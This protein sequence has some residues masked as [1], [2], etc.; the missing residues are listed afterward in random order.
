MRGAGRAASW[1]AP[2]FSRST[3]PGCLFRPQGGSE[4]KPLSEFR[5]RWVGAGK[6]VKYSRLAL[7]EPRLR[8][9]QGRNARLGD[10]GV[11]TA[12]D[13]ADP[14]RADAL[15]ANHDGHATFQHALD[16]GSTEE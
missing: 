8:L 4:G 6:P 5:E 2:G 11:F 7:P 15:A 12:L 14:D 1:K 16:G 9:L 10:L 3:S 13:T